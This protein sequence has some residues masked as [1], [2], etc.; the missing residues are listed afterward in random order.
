MVL[1]QKDQWKRTD[2]LKIYP[3]EYNQL[4]FAK[5]AKVIKWEKRQSFQKVV[6]EQLDINMQKMNPD[7]DLTLYT[8]INSM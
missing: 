4:I 1:A 8:K 6:L 5:G 7:T 2:S 3:H